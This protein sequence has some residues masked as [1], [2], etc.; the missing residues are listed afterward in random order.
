MSENE[1]TLLR[2]YFPSGSRGQIIV[3][4]RNWSV[5]SDIG[6]ECLMVESLTD[7]EAVELLGKSAKMDPPDVDSQARD[8]QRQIAAKLLGRH[9][10]A[11]AQAGLIFATKYR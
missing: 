6:A 1:N 5:A 11:I 8:L 3:T 9:P 10:L 4:S 7:Q 2:N